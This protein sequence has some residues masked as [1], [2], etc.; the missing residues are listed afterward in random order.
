[1]EKSE[2][3]VLRNI[4]FWLEKILFKESDG[5]ISVIQTP[6]ELL[7]YLSYSPDLAASDYWLFADLKRMFQGKRFGS[8]KEV[9]SEIEAYFEAKDKSFYKKKKTTTNC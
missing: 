2:F 9:I 5:L 1:M 8:Y 4:A 3:H 7:T 6:F